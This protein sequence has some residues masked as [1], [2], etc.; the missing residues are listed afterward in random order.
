MKPSTVTALD[1]INRR[2]YDEQ[3][4][5]F[6]QTRQGPWAGWAQVAEIVRD[7]LPA[8]RP[9]T[10]LDVGCGNGRF[11]RFLAEA[12]P[13]TRIRWAGLDASA[14]L[15]G[16]AGSLDEWANLIDPVTRVWHLLGTDGAGP[17]TLPRPSSCWLGDSEPRVP[18]AHDGFDLVVAFGVFHHVPG[19]LQAPLLRRMVEATRRGGLVIV[20]FWQFVELEHYDKR[21]IDWSE[22]VDAGWLDRESTTE[23]EP[24][25]WLLRWGDATELRARYCRAT[26]ETDAR[27]VLAAAGPL[28]DVE[29]FR[30]DGRTG[31]LNLYAVAERPSEGPRAKPG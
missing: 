12:L 10:V 8:G 4:K 2:F 27:S 16:W 7:R 26:G 18:G 23:L 6:D 3:A 22:A 31:E 11:G 13:D 20:S 29:W 28:P 24:E 1:R 15:L 25:D 9:L 30:A 5:D 14:T 19:P 21:R 17:P